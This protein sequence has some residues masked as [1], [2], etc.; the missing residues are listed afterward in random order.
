MWI[1]VDVYTLNLEDVLYFKN[2]TDANGQGYMLVFDFS[3]TIKIYLPNS[4]DDEDILDVLA[5]IDLYLKNKL[6]NQN[7]T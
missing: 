6:R 1:R 3:H 2:I 7:G 5:K 4:T